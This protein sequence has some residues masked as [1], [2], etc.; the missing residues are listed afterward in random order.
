MLSLN[1]RFVV[2]IMFLLDSYSCYCVCILIE[3]SAI[4]APRD[5]TKTK[6]TKYILWLILMQ[7]V[8]Y[9][10]NKDIW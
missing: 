7:I 8:T 5:A 3:L 6:K 2:Y 4:F 10:L 9:G 1:I